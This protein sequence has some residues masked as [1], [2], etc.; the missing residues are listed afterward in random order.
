[1]KICLRICCD[2]GV[3]G[4]GLRGLKAPG[5]EPSA[6]LDNRGCSMGRVMGDFFPASLD[7]FELGDFFTVRETRV[8][9]K[10][11]TTFGL[12]GGAA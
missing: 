4:S 3:E 5:S 7:F 12:T 8:K 9:E 6:R 10:Q 1:M 2:L 11:N